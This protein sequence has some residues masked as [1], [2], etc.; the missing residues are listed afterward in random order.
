[1]RIFKNK[2]FVQFAR[3]EKIGDELLCEAVE[4][5]ER[6]L[7]DADLGG[8]VIKQ[9]IARP[10][11]GRSGG[12]RSIVLFRTSERAIFVFGFAKNQM[13]NITKNN[14]KAFRILAGA[15][16]DYDDEELEALLK[17]GEAIEVNCDEE[18]LSR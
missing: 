4:R 15:L 10:N 7:I 18:D 3:H 16:L 8:G 1:M 2:L 13:E 6:G 11:R 14:L 17:S 9:R 5:A 12:Y